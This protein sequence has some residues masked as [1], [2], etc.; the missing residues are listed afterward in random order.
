MAYWLKRTAV[1]WLG[2]GAILLGWWFLR[3]AAGLPAI[4]YLGWDEA[5]HIQLFRVWV[6]GI[7][8]QLTQETG[9]VTTFVVSPDGRWLVYAV[10]EGEN[11]FIK[12]TKATGF[13]SETLLTCPKATCEG[14]VWRP[15]SGQLVYERRE[16]NTPGLTRLW[17]LDVE[18]HESQPLVAG[19][20]MG[21]AVRFAPDGQWLSYFVSPDAG[22]YVTH[23]ADGR[24]LN[25][26]SEMGT[27][28]VWSPDNQSLLVRNHFVVFGAEGA[29][30]AVYLYRVDVATR[31][32]FA[33]SQGVVDDG[34]PEWSPDGAW[35]A[36]GRKIPRTNAG[37]QLWLMRPNGSEAHALTN[38]AAIYH[39][40]PHWSP[41]GR[42]LLYQK[43]ALTDTAAQ[44]SLWLLEIANGTETAVVAPGFQPVWWPSPTD[45]P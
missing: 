40:P 27:P 17:W 45:T 18:S 29:A 31:S 19:E 10:Q 42:Y 38:S 14:L 37:Q 9:D 21:Q 39:G 15:G 2:M 22:M 41:D 34:V 30:L 43:Y 12:R 16:N 33:L 11:S 3:P 35:I 28:A 1:I 7:P 36:F 4:A 24:Y 5:G 23:L 13:A 44:P 32:S 8:Q 25:I 6:G 20:G 26:P